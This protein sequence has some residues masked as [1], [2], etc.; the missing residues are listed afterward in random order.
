MLVRR[1]ILAVIS[2]GLGAIVTEISLIL[3]NTNRAEYGLYFGTDGDG[4]PYYPLT[5]IFFALF[6]ALWLD[7]FLKTELLPK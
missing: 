1:T 5:I 7:K 3:M 6:F 4:L 2:L